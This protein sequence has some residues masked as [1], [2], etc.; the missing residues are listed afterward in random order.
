MFRHN[1][2][3]FGQSKKIVKA[4]DQFCFFNFSVS[5]FTSKRLNISTSQRLN[6]V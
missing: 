1:G 5:A 4:E 6:F 2:I 3:R